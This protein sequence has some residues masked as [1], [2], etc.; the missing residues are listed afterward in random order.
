MAE[1][2][3]TKFRSL[4]GPLGLWETILLGAIP[5][6]GV[7]FVS[8]AP[9]YLGLAILKEQYLGVFLALVLGAVFLSVPPSVHADRDRV[10]WYDLV[11]SFLGLA[12]GLYPALYFNEIMLTMGEPDALRLALG[13]IAILLILEALRR[14]VGWVLVAVG[15]FFLFYARFANYFPG[16][17]AGT[18]VPWDRLVNYLYTDVNSLFGL[19]LDVAAIIV[20]TYIFFGQILFAIGAGKFLTDSSMA[21]FGRRRGGESWPPAGRP[22]GCRRA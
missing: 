8:D 12:V 11:L 1:I 22:G 17:F 2:E 18:G 5:L 21:L 10:P 4:R 15:V 3:T 9:F 6:A 16:G 7:F 14:T 19:P 20:L 13:A